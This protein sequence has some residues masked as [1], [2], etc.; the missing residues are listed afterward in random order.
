MENEDGTDGVISFD[1]KLIEKYSKLYKRL[2][3]KGWSSRRIKKSD[4]EIIIGPRVPVKWIGLMREIL[5]EVSMSQCLLNKQNFVKQ[6]LLIH[7]YKEKG[8]KKDEKPSKPNR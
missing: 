8:R 6:A 7:S 4:V 1:L 2:N 3:L 5:S